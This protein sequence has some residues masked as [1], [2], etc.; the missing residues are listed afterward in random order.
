MKYIINKGS[1]NHLIIT[2]H[3]T[4]GTASSL[5]EIAKFID[6]L[7]SK[8]GFQGE[9]IENGMNRYFVRYPEGGFDLES[10][11]KATY[12]LNDSILKLIDKYKFEKYNITILGY[13]N[14]ANLAKNLFKEFEN[15]KVDNAL[16][17]HPSQIT[18]EVD[19]KEQ[20][21]LNVF[22]TSGR[23]DPYI[24]EKEFKELKNK[25]LAA[26]VHVETFT[27]NLGH[28]LVQEELDYA[29]DFLSKLNNESYNGK[30]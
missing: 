20:K 17:F 21:N 1:N 16:L 8:V 11:A 13:S 14:G 4:G 12:D 19:F 25:L 18:P 24:S 27:H 10:L 22:L 30:V 15:V 5:F 26:K 7:A 29:K 6:P 9:V 23:N 2:L 3:G 28:Q